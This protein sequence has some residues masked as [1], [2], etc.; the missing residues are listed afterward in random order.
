[1]N[2]EFNMWTI[3]QTSGVGKI[4]LPRTRAED[5]SAP[6]PTQRRKRRVYSSPDNAANLDNCRAG[7]CR[8]PRKSSRPPESLQKTRYATYLVISGQDPEASVCCYAIKTV[9]ENKN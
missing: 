2:A 1:M 9:P 8:P 4:G 3:E 6:E 5:R 7:P